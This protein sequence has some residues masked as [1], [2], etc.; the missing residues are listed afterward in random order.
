MAIE[1]KLPELGEN[2]ES[3]DIVKVHVSPGD[4]V[5]VDQVVLEIE[6][7]KANVEVPSEIA[8]TVKEVFVKDGSKA[9]VGDVIF[10][11]ESEGVKTAEEKPKQ[12]FS[13][14]EPEK[15]EKKPEE[16][17]ASEAKETEKKEGEKPKSK[18]KT[19]AKK[20]TDGRNSKGRIIVP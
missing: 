19:E 5:N 4:T 7:D 6:T 2:I 8:G 11:V 10:T 1:F 14:P 20:T 3:A 18:A 16:K 13:K 9:K 15:V 17:K 12:E